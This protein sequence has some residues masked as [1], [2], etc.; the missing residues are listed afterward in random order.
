MREEKA[1]SL[2][3]LIRLRT[4]LWNEEEREGQCHGVSYFSGKPEE[5]SA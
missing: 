3:K 5:E 1:S 4:W 2:A